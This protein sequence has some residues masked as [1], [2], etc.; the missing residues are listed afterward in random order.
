M[1]GERGDFLT[2]HWSEIFS[3]QTTDDVR[4]EIVMDRLLRRYWKPVYCRIRHQG[5]DNE[6]AKDLTQGFFQDVVLDSNLIAQADD[7]KGRFRAF[8][9]TALKHYLIS[10]KRKETAK[11]RR[12]LGRT[13]VLEANDLPELPRARSTMSPDQVFH[14]VWATEIVDQVIAQVE[15]ECRSAGKEKHWQVFHAK[16]LAP[17]MKNQPGPPLRAL[18]KEHGIASEA[19]ASNMIITVKRCFRRTLEDQLRRFVQTDAD[20][21]DELN[22][23]LGIFARGGAG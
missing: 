6:Q 8:L 15:R 5:Y 13:L 2:T 9:L 18:C 14:Y 1:G 3:A 10:M 4:R 11:K 17:I 19:K 12:P 7:G 20:I 16:V 21:E 22:E 23:L